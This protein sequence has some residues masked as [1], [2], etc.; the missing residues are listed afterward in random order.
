MADVRAICRGGFTPANAGRRIMTQPGVEENRR[1]PLA[2]SPQSRLRAAGIVL[3]RPRA[4][5]ANYAATVQEGF[6]LFRSGQGPVTDEGR[7]G[8]KV[9]RDTTSEEAYHHA[10][11]AGLNLLA[12]IEAA[13]GSLDRVARI[14]KVLGMVNAVED[15]EDHPRV[16][17]GCSDLFVQVFGEE[18]GIHARSAIGVASLPGN[19]TVEIEVV[20]AVRAALDAP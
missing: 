8:G 16:I 2:E 12:N 18:A 6:L 11:L 7:R 10:R 19:I 15:F 20:V 14:V 4:P 17:N 13:L 9:G 1:A 5:V 3:P